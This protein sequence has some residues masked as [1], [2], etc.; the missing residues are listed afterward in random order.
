MDLATGPVPISRIFRNL[1]SANFFI[2][3]IMA[4]NPSKFERVISKFFE[5]EKKFVAF[6]ALTIFEPPYWNQKFSDFRGAAISAQ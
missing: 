5:T 2:N 6:E 4:A 3:D 1:K